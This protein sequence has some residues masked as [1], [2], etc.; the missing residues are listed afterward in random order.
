MSQYA[1]HEHHAFLSAA[2]EALDNPGLQAALTRLTDTLMEGNRCGYATLPGSDGL[3]DRAKR[4][5]EHT[6]AN[7]DRYLEQL[8]ASVLRVGGL[9]HWARTAE[10][11][12]QI[13]VAIARQTNCKKAVKSKSMTAEEIH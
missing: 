13:V 3:R 4:I 10:E 5:K 2:W 6:L 1:E 7:L 8:E 9:V 12:R 11:A